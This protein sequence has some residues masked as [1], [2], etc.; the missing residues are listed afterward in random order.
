MI[1]VG[2]VSQYLIPNRIF[3]SS[4]KIVVN[5]LKWASNLSLWV[6]KKDLVQSVSNWEVPSRKRTK[7]YR[8][9]ISYAQKH[10]FSLQE[11]R[12]SSYVK[13]LFVS[14]AQIL[15]IKKRR[16]LPVSS[17][18]TLPMLLIHALICDLLTHL[19]GRFRATEKFCRGT[20]VAC[21]ASHEC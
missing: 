11:E 20:A 14:Y 16:Y 12:S 15:P 2:L 9:C 1:R 3:K 19:R 7:Q 13:S 8:W 21:R 10:S 17:D 4:M 6:S 5:C 18:M